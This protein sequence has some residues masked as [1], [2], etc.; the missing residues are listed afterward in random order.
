MPKKTTA[1]VIGATGLVGKQLTLRLLEDHR[2]G[3]VRVFVRRSL[4][5]LHDELDERIVDFE[6][7]P[8]WQEGLEGDVLFSTFGTTMAQVRADKRT[9][10]DARIAFAH[11]D[12][13]IPLEIARQAKVHGVPRV[14]VLSSIGAS[15][16]ALFVYLA[17]KGKL[18]VAIRTLGFEE[19]VILRPSALVGDREVSRS[20]EKAGI[21]SLKFLAGLGM[22]NLR[23]ID[24]SVVAHVMA[25]LGTARLD[26]ND[27]VLTS[28]EISSF[29]SDR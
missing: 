19:S 3:R 18:D 10:L 27:M 1:L 23:P 11:I 8:S 2:Y 29:F 17:L 16:R 14:V 22:S 9:N 20:S 15:D 25:E 21:A 24:A 28:K 13:D 12:H 6:D 4:G 26:G 5:L 7:I